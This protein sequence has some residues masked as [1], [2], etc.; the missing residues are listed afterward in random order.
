[1]HVPKLLELSAEH[2]RMAEAQMEEQSENAWQIVD[3]P[4]VPQVT[5]EQQAVIA[6]VEVW[7]EQT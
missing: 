2:G 3:V 5:G 1:M 6:V 7:P 4:R